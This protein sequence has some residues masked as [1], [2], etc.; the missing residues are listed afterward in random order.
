MRTFFL[1][2]TAAFLVFFAGLYYLLTHFAT[3]T[4]D[5]VNVWVETYF[6]QARVP[7]FTGFLTLGSF[8]LTLQT[9]IIQRLKD[10]FD[11]DAYKQRYLVLKGRKPKTKYYGS[12][13]RMSIALST[14]VILALATA[15]TQLTAG[16]V[17]TEWST[18]LCVAIAAT[19][20][21]LVVYLTIQLLLAHNEWFVKI[22]AARQK[23]LET[24]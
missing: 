4:S 10:A 23:E 24:S 8:L 20:V 19:S 18:A 21:G 1:I 9:T 12:L 22:E 11:T 14:N 2:L 16:F 7:M 5:S 17:R 13:E 3:V 6:T 15:V